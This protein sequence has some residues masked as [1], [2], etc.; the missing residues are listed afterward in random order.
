[1]RFWMSS[2]LL[3]FTYSHT[4]RFS[5][6]FKITTSTWPHNVWL[7]HYIACPRGLPKTSPYF[8]KSQAL[9]IASSPW[10]RMTLGHFG[11][12][13]L[14]MKLCEWMRL[15]SFCFCTALLVETFSILTDRCLGVQWKDCKFDFRS[16]CRGLNWC[17]PYLS[18]LR[19]L[20]SEMC[21][22]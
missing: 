19:E 4:W 20:N 12:A 5:N 16:V 3:F 13:N 1:M 17:C 8:T 11:A 21:S 2:C 7:V 18:S 9:E 14:S 15:Y 10:T 22:Q 6:I